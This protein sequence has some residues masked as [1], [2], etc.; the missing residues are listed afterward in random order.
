[1]ISVVPITSIFLVF[2]LRSQESSDLMNNL[3]NIQRMHDKSKL[4]IYTHSKSFFLNWLSHHTTVCSFVTPHQ[5]LKND[6]HFIFK[7][8]TPWQVQIR[9]VS[10]TQF[11]TIFT[12]FREYRTLPTRYA[13]YLINVLI[14]KQIFGLSAFH[15]F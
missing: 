2:K 8:A 5:P 11:A 6:D 14:K 15:E 7:A 4:F 13:E 1:M 3:S 12:L 10:L 9:I